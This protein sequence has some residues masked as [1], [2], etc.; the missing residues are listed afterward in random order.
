MEWGTEA[1]HRKFLNSYIPY[2]GEY[3]RC[4][5]VSADDSGTFALLTHKTGKNSTVKV[6]TTEIPAED[7]IVFPYTVAESGWYH[8]KN[9]SEVWYLITRKVYKSFSVGFNEMSHYCYSISGGGG[10]ATGNLKYVDFQKKVTSGPLK[11][12]RPFHFKWAMLGGNLYYLSTH[13]GIF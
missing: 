12:N 5:G 4:D 2:Q 11:P 13:C 1:V 8:S 9:D 10:F 6:T 7:G 3:V